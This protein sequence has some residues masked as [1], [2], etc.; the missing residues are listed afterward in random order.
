MEKNSKIDTII[1]K[2]KWKFDEGVTSTFIN[3]LERSIPQYDI[4][5]KSVYNLGCGIL[6][7]FCEK[8]QYNILDLGCSNGLALENFISAYGMKSTYTGV[9]VSDPMLVEA[10]SRFKKYIDPPYNYPIYIYKED[11]RNKF[12]E[13]H[14]YN[15]ILSVLTVQ[16]IPIEYRQNLIQKVY[17]TLSPNGGFIMVEKVLGNTACLNDMFVEEYLKM[18]TCNG[19]TEEQIERKRF[20]LEGVLVPMTSTW[21]IDMLKQAGFKKIDTFWRW[22]NFEG[23]ICIK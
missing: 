1:P 6:E 23:L 7:K 12:P 20:S 16:F 8:E 18:K 15:L 13:F 22:M 4:M 19:Y 10:K 9:D 17:D 5:R 11:L 3:M 2:D 14:K 21:N